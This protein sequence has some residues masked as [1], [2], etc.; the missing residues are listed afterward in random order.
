MGYPYN[1][2][3]SPPEWIEFVDLYRAYIVRQLRELA[4]YLTHQEPRVDDWAWDEWRRAAM[5][6]YWRMENESSPK[7]Q[8][9]ITN[10]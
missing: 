5:N 2:I 9:Q 7:N 4:A 8:A 3:P 1:C 6:D 10:I